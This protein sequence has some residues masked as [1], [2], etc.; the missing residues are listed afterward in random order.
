MKIILSILGII[1]VI[2]SLLYFDHYLYNKENQK[3]MREGERMSFVGTYLCLPPKDEG[4]TTADCA[5]GIKTDEGV[6]YALDLGLL[7]SEAPLMVDQDRIEAQGIVTPLERLSTDYW[8]KYPVV[9][10]FSVTDSLRVITK[11]PDTNHAESILDSSWVWE[12]TLL[13]NG[14]RIEAKTGQKFLLS[15][16]SAEKYI[17]STDCNSVSGNVIV[18]REVVSF[19][20]GASTKMFCEN[21]QEQE[22][23]RD[24]LLTNAY[25]IERDT[26]LLNL[27]R[28]YGTMTFTR[29]KAE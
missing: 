14:E 13:K 25:S 21:S 20:E 26:L 23:I 15:F 3:E 24:L 27:N 5:I 29:K 1:A 8:Q 9:G 6:Y 17:S 22:Y 2:A 4:N 18:D 19:G 7:S 10:I 12:H 28:D 16:P 11:I